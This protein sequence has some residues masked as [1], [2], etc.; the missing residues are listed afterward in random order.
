[1]V[2]IAVRPLYFAYY[3]I[4]AIENSHTEVEES[5]MT[6]FCIFSTYFVEYNFPVVATSRDKYQPNAMATEVMRV[7]SKKVSEGGEIQNL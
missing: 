5:Y 6:I 1:M 2:H 3:S 4:L 7:A